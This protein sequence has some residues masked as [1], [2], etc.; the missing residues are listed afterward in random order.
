M[1]GVPGKLAWR[2]DGDTA[3]IALPDPS[4][5]PCDYRVGVANP[6]QNTRRLGAPR[7]AIFY[8]SNFHR[9]PDLLLA[10]ADTFWKVA[11]I[12]S[13]SVSQPLKPDSRIAGLDRLRDGSPLILL[14]AITRGDRLGDVRT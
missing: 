9:D 7:T 10:Y 2:M 13:T 1:L 12:I 3:V 8:K 5:K 6:A 14:G 11:I 4:S